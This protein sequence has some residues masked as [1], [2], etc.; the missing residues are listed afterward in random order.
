MSAINILLSR[1][2]FPLILD[3]R[4]GFWIKLF[5]KIES[6]RNDKISGKSLALSITIYHIIEINSQM[7]LK[8]IHYGKLNLGSEELQLL[9][10]G[11][12]KMFGVSFNDM[13]NVSINKNDIIIE[14]AVE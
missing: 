3:R 4:F 12:D 6:R 7:S 5:Y 13:K 1:Q 14:T 9:S 8:G 11:S 2:I 10:M